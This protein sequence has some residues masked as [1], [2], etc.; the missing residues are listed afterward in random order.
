[1][2]I[3][4]FWCNFNHKEGR[5]ITIIGRMFLKSPYRGDAK[6][7]T[8]TYLPWEPRG[9]IAPVV[10]DKLCIFTARRKHIINNL[11]K[12]HIIPLAGVGQSFHRS[13]PSA[14]SIPASCH[15]TPLFLMSSSITSIHSFTGLPLF[16][17]FS[18][19]SSNTF[20]ISISSSHL[21]TC[22]NH[23]FCLKCSSKSSTLTLDT[24]LALLFLNIT[25]Q[26]IRNN[27]VT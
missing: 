4:Y 25:L 8:P 11:V 14:F 12:Q 22:P 23:L 7:R 20:F 3:F 5:N 26:I 10:L 15:T 21:K 6:Y 17:L 18:I 1:M 9:I 13:H 16:L 27:H 2:M 19:F 24:I